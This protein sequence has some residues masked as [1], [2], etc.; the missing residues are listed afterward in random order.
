MFPAEKHR[1]KPDLMKASNAFFIGILM[2]LTVRQAQAQINFAS[3]TTYNYIYSKQRLLKTSSGKDS[4]ENI[5]YFDGLG[6]PIQTVNYKQSPNQKDMIQPVEY[7][8]YG[9]EV[10]KYLPY[11]ATSATGIFRSTWKTEQST[12]HTG[13]YGSTDGTKAFAQTVFDNSPLN[14]VMKQG[15]PGNAWKVVNTS[16]DRQS[17]EHIVSY[18]YTA[19]AANE[20]YYW[21]I[22][23]T[24]PN[25]TFTRYSYNAN[26]LYKNI[27]N[28]EN[29]NPVTEYKD[30]QGKVVLKTDALGGK[31]CYIYDDFDLLRC[32]IPPLAS[33]TLATTSSFTLSNTTCS[34]LCYYYEY[35][36]RHR[37]VSK[38]LPGTVGIYAMA[39]DDLDRLIQTTDPNGT[40]SYTKYDVFSR[41]IETGI[42]VSNSKIWKTKSIYDTYTSGINYSSSS[43]YQ[44]QNVYYSSYET[45]VKGKPTVGKTKIINPATDM[46]TDS[47][48]ITVTYYD[49]YGRIIQTVSNNLKGGR[50]RVS[51]KYKYINSDL[52][53]ETRNDHGISGT[54]ASHTVIEKHSYDNTGRL[55]S[56]RHK[57][58]T[59]AETIMDSL[60]YN[61]AGQLITKNIN[62]GL[63]IVDYKYN[64]RNWLT[65]INNPYDYSGV[66]K[67][68]LRLTYTGTSYNGN[69]TKM[70]WSNHLDGIVSVSDLGYDNLNRLTGAGY[71]EY[72]RGVFL[73][74][75]AGKYVESFGY[76][77]NGNI[78][79]LQRNGTLN[80][81]TGL[82]ST[83]D[84]LSYKYFS[85]EKSNRLWAVGDFIPD[86]Y[87]RGDFN[88]SFS[89]GYD[90]Q[91]FFY[92]NNGNMIQDKNRNAK[93]SY[94]FLNLPEKVDNG[95]DLNVFK[96]IYDA[97]GMKL[98]QISSIGT[99]VTNDY[100]GPFVYKNGVLDYIITNEGRAVYSSGTFSFYEY[101][102]KDHLGNVR[103]VFKRYGSLPDVMQRNDYYAFGSLM[104]ES[105][106]SI[107]TN[108]KYRYNGKENMTAVSS[109]YGVDISWYDYGARFYDPQIGRWHSVDPSSEKYNS[110]SPYNYGFNSPI[111]V[112]DPDGRDAIFT[113]QRNKK[114]EIIGINIS[115]TIHI[116]GEGASADKANELNKMSSG[117]F[118]PN[119]QSN[120]NISFNISFQYD[121]TIDKDNIKK[122]DNI[123][124]FGKT[125]RDGNE[126]RS[127]VSMPNDGVHSYTTNE[128]EILY[129]KDEKSW[130]NW[131]VFHESFH[132]LG[133]SDRYSA[134]G[135]NQAPGF[136]N[137]I[138]SRRDSYKIG[139]THY[140]D[141]YNYGMGLG[142]NYPKHKRFINYIVI[143][144]RNSRLSF[145]TQKQYDEDK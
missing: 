59:Q 69:I 84:V 66:D 7:D 132:L 9:R 41:P 130:T 2:L 113:I 121:E 50:D 125:D 49:K 65:Q 103:C 40:I 94:N 87:G 111:N 33:S 110:M 104:G 90:I 108:N 127:H 96:Y 115:S 82:I 20:V 85:S 57:I 124:Y 60:T 91:E 129:H 31:T 101:H 78:S 55:I 34:E 71:I 39:Y 102:L 48:L 81:G 134:G 15:A 72:N 25:I 52:I 11:T 144:R 77:A 26:T 43:F 23:G 1:F 107:Y 131:S 16:T 98:R 21:V 62:S 133:L 126:T 119:I 120:V 74:A 30:R 4:L 14:R 19:N 73:P 63:Q 24:Y 123:L 106:T 5:Q 51:H 53:I 44:Y 141:Y 79:W 92:D 64:I 109:G 122:G 47:T 105:Y 27:V 29:N 142:N 36:Y 138:M 86:S 13:L 3:L 100:I 17:T 28:D 67:F 80:D 22:S 139:D 37:M 32:V 112:I 38:R 136:G 35:D 46:I 114:G 95:S 42:Y 135:Y 12:F 6:R 18:K 140:R 45:K 54:T 61:E 89:D 128:G 93:I 137:D 56:N 99:T 97:G 58:D 118:K 76:D 8:L 145:P 75:S 10:N 83:F 68:A 70:E 117:V 116:T 88:E 143:D